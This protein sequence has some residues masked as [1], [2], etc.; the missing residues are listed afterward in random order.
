[1]RQLTEEERE[2]LSRGAP[3]DNN[4]CEQ[5]LKRAVLHRKNALFL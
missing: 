5:A 2:E 4:I 3:L 1:L